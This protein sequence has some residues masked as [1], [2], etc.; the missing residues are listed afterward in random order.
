MG[1]DG[2]AEERTRRS[3]RLKAGLLRGARDFVALVWRSARRAGADNLWMLSAGVAFY[4]FL[5]VFPAIAGTLMI[6]GLFADPAQIREQVEVVRGVAPPEAFDLVTTQ[7]M[8]I[9][10]A[11][12][13]GSTVG[14]IFSLLF[15]L[16]SASRAAN[17][18]MFTLNVAYNVEQPRG[19]FAA[20]W[21]AIRF[22]VVAIGFG[23]LSLAAISAVPPVL[24]AL[25][26]GA[27]ADALLRSARWG[28][29]IVIFFVVTTIAYRRTPNY[30]SRRESYRRRPA[31][32]PGALAAS[33]IWLASSFGFSFY[34]SEFEAYNETF[35][36][37]GAVAAL[38]MWFWLSAYAVGIGA[39]VNMA[40]DARRMAR[41]IERPGTPGDPASGA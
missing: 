28:L 13:P 5:S 38:L 32:K 10:E 29:L 31:T 41:R 33:A 34:L 15:A 25:R 36:S 2:T 24:D 8:Q 21:A 26:I 20:N 12:G 3:A 40:I 4:A 7:M 17:A 9:A 6:W 16:W 18:M 39:E 19:F 35:G 37:L 11:S 30:R 27:V 1:Q 14:A 23:L 22:T